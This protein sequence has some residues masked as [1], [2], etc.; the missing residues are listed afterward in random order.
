LASVN[1]RPSPHSRA[2]T[3]LPE[4]KTTLLDVDSDYTVPPPFDYTITAGMTFREAG[5]LFIG[6]RDRDSS[7]ARRDRETGG[8]RLQCDRRCYRALNKTFG[9]VLL[10]TIRPKDLDQYRQ[11]RRE[12]GDEIRFL[13]NVLRRAK[14]WSEDFSAGSIEPAPKP[15]TARM[16]FDAAFPA[17]LRAHKDVISER[18]A[19]DYWQYGSALSAYFGC[20]RLCDLT[21]E[22]LRGFQAWRFSQGTGSGPDS[23]YRY[24]AGAVR[25]KNEINGVLKPL[26]KESG[27]WD[28]ISHRFKH[29][30]VSRDGAGCALAPQEVEQ[31]L[32]VA[33]SRPRWKVA[34]A[35][36]KIMYRT[37][38]GVGELR[39]LRRRDVDLDAGTISVVLGAKNS[40]ARVRKLALVPSALAAIRFLVKRW[41]QKGGV[42]PDD[43][44]LPHRSGLKSDALCDFTRPMAGIYGAFVAIRREWI[45]KCKPP[46]EKHRL[47]LYDARVTV[48]SMLLSNPSLSL[49]TIERTLGWSPSSAM[50]RRY[51]KADTET[52]RAALNTLEARGEP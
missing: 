40:G 15:I 41:K 22:D 23:K 50:R 47:R 28:A 21:T 27:A 31:L 8:A 16:P 13:T 26:L 5:A 20:R 30:P 39:R 46:A 33:S 2:S 19:R 9:E 10:S 18:T 52:Q 24:S 48:A 51:F 42:F 35:L 29:L 7:G 45:R 36:L 1:F 12:C 17:W 37:G 14:L 11:G 34:A 25:V 44:L 49:P 3:I 43:F 32:T 38:T 4:Q 6:S